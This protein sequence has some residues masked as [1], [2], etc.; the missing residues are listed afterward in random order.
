[1]TGL[2]DWAR[3]L[4]VSRGALVEDDGEGALRALLPAEVAGALAS[5]D[6]LSLNFMSDAGADDPAEWLERLG[7][8]LPADRP[9]AG[10]RLRSFASALPVDAAAVLAHEFVVQNGVYR[11][12]D[13]GPA[14]ASYFFFT[15]Q[16]TV[17]SDDR[18]I[19]I[20]TVCLNSSVGSLVP[21]PETF[22]RAVRDSLEDDPEFR[23]PAGELRRFY[24]L[25]LR[26]VQA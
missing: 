18:S 21:Q 6:W 12:A 19:G 11:L 9:V 24:S 8:L 1:M 26:S 13:E 2:V 23:S 4:L 17:E 15:F 20:V 25:A 14:Y 5:S 10:A 16:Y 22:L 3:D 7:A